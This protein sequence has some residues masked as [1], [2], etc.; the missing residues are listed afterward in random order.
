M[1]TD[2]G[3]IDCGSRVDGVGVSHGDKGGTTITEQ[4]LKKN[5][6]T[7]L[8]DRDKI[9]LHLFCCFTSSAALF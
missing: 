1:G 8:C 9:H 6:H 5:M 2:N 4:Q 3:G 7:E